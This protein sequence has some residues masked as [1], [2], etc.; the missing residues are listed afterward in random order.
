MTLAVIEVEALLEVVVAALVAGV[1]VTVIFSLVIY[2]ATRASELR[3]NDAPV[4][5]LFLGGIAALG[6]VACL[7]G[8]AFGIHVMTQK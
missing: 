8:V 6:L 2:F 5:A 3:Q 4:L 7:A 1:G